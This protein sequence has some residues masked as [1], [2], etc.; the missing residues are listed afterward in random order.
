MKTL[1][2]VIGMAIVIAFSANMAM[3]G[4]SQN[5]AALKT[6]NTL[7]SQMLRI[8][9]IAWDAP[10]KPSKDY[11][12]ALEMLNDLSPEIDAYG[13]H[14]LSLT[15]K[16]KAADLSAN[17]QRLQGAAKKLKKQSSD[18]TTAFGRLAVLLPPRIERAVQENVLGAL[19]TVQKLL[20]RL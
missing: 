9:Q 6:A 5:S 2:T 20:P 7:K 15:A 19:S 18:F 10:G 8:K 12:R 14:L 3:A 16:K 4:S 11:G 1:I 17:E 13:D